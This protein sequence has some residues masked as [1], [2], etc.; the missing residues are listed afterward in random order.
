MTIT[1][2]TKK[3]KGL[4]TTLEVGGFQ[5]HS[6]DGEQYGTKRYAYLSVT[7]RTMD[8]EQRIAL[9]R[10]AQSYLSQMGYKVD[11]DWNRA[12]SQLAVFVGHYNAAQDGFVKI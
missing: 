3:G 4:L 5:V 7:P 6:L 2:K 11:Y 8:I 9:K 10:K 12:G 1:A